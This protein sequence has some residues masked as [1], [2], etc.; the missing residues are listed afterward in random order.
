MRGRWVPPPTEGKASRKG[1]GYVARGQ[2][3]LP[4]AGSNTA[5]RHAT[6]PPLFCEPFGLLLCG[7]VVQQRPPP[8]PKSPQKGVG[9]C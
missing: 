4:A 9:L 8:P 1:Q 5:R 3:A 7:R 2:W 6:P